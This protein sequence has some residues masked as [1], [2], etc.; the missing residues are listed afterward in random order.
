MPRYYFDTRDGAGFVRDWEGLEF[1]D[2]DAAR[3]EAAK[4]L[5]CMARDALQRASSRML[6]IEV[7]DHRKEPLLAARLTFEVTPL[8]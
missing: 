5:G 7:R 3:D 8:R 2:D 6:S 1:P 4:A